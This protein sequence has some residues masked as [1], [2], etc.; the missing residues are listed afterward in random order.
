MKVRHFQRMWAVAAAAGLALSVA[1]AL[2][3]DATNVAQPAAVNAPAPP[4]AYGVSDIL[5]LAQAKVSEEA[6]VAYIK[7]S[8][9]S[10]GLNADQIIYLRQQGVSDAVIT[11][12]LNQPKPG[13]APATVP[14]PTTPAPQPVPMV[15]YAQPAEPYVETWPTPY[16]AYEPYYYPV[17]GS[18]YWPWRVAV[19]YGWGGHWYRGWHG[20]GWHVGGVWRGG[21]AWHGGGAWRGGWHGGGGG[22]AHG[23]GHAGWHR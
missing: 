12:M 6:I 2:A 19:S 21:S 4:L 8:G 3:Q 15:T 20:G 1:M 17:Y 18:Y 10:Y 23:G 22:V 13:V 5:K 7:V 14:V 16:Y 11:A 9:I